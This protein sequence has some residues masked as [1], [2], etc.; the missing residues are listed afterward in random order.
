[1]MTENKSDFLKIGWY[2]IIGGIV[3]EFFVFFS[4]TQVFGQ[5][6]GSEVLVYIFMLLFFV[7]SVFCGLLCITYKN[8]ALTFSLINQFLQLIGFA[9]LG[10]GFTYVAGFY[11]SIDLNFSDAGLGFGFGLSIFDFNINREYDKAELHFNLIALGL[12][13]W[14]IKLSAKIKAE[15]RIIAKLEQ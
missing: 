1:M 7:Y 2:Q 4:P 15:K 5:V 11:I 8:N 13:S 6:F 3:G 12:I 14:I 9:F 10:F